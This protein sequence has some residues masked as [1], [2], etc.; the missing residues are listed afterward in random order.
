M[1]IGNKKLKKVSS[2][3]L[4]KKLKRN[5]KNNESNKNNISSTTRDSMIKNSANNSTI[6]PYQ[7]HRILKKIKLNNKNNNNSQ[8]SIN[9]SQVI[10]HNL[11]STTMEIIK[12]ADNIIKER[13]KFQ[14]HER[15]NLIRSLVLKESKE[16]SYHNY[17]IKLLKEKRIQLNEKEIMVNKIL[18]DFSEQY[19]K[20]YRT[21]MNFI[22]GMKYKER[23]DVDN[24]IELRELKEKKGKLLEEER[25]LNKRLEE[26][27]ERKI[28]ELYITRT[29]ASFIHKIL[30]KDFIYSQLPQLK[31]RNKNIEE[32]SNLL[33]KIYEEKGKNF[34][35]LKEIGNIDN[36][37]EKY[38][39]IEEKIISGMTN[40]EFQ[41]KENE[42]I[43]N[44]YNNELK[45][46]K[47]SIIDYESDLNY[48]KN[49]KKN[50]NIEMGNFQIHE[51]ENFYKHLK[52]IIELGTALETNEEIP[53]KFDK[54]NLIDF[55]FYSNKTVK[56]LR[57]IEDKIN[58]N[59]LEIENVFNFGNKEEK[60]L[61]ENIISKQK[62][63]NLTEKLINWKKLREEKKILEI[64][65][66]NEKGKK[67]VLK[68]RK[69]IFDYPNYKN[70]SKIKKPIEK[71]DSVKKNN[72]TE[73]I[74]DYE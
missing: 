42:K 66:I 16:M 38:K 28:K 21:F 31:T 20:D 33:I 11:N 45:Q 74:V 47:Q 22:E 63:L 2:L 67:F 61:M 26:I 57:N 68:G 54:N 8:S 15:K 35:F 1:L 14:S 32:I 49:E 44:N 13:K 37:M 17:Y 41:D 60:E 24:I 9:K 65:K 70:K 73:I 7:S 25:S 43:K 51:D 3:P 55:V 46:L 4:I 69:V 52:Y 36:F 62:S 50:I 40:K 56:K 6:L 71:E 18:K 34:N 19:N 53:T 29:Y 39:E 23:N 72:F 64:A 59:I 12:N 10:S 48:L 58:K 30:E 27:L 5:N